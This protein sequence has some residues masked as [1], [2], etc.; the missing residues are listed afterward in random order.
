[1]AA[2]ELVDSDKMLNKL[3]NFFSGTDKEWIEVDFSRWG[4]TAGDNNKFEQLKTAIINE[5]AV[6][7]DYISAYGEYKDCEVH[8]LKLSFK[9]KAWYLQAFYPVEND[10]RIYKFNR[11]SNIT[12]LETS[13]STID[14]DISQIAPP[15][16]P[17]PLDITDVKV[18]ISSHAKY[19]VYDEFAESDIIVN[20][21]GSFTLRMT[22]GMWIPD[23][24]LSYGT[25]IEVLEP[26]SLRQTVMT[27]LDEVKQK[28]LSKT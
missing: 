18:R 19:R 25:A 26:A 14:H 6:K 2:T 20:E 17:L 13:F 12:V 9:S 8:P 5:H 23:Y 15:E 1:M 16:D 28:Y 24:I 21:D 11:I 4:H 22:H 7:F 10:Y 3:R 27:R